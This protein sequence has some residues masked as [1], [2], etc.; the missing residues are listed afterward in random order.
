MMERKGSRK[1]DYIEKSEKTGNP[2]IAL[3]FIV[4]LYIYGNAVI[5]YK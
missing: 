1:Y 2:Y 3:Y 4:I 5:R